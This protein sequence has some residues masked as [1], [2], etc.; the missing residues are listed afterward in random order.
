M[1][2]ILGRSWKS[3]ILVPLNSMITSPCSIPAFSAGEPSR[4]WLTMAPPFSLSPKLSASS[5]VTGWI[6]T[7]NSARV[8]LPLSLSWLT[9]SLITLTG[10]ANPMPWPR[11][12][13]AVFMPTT[14]P[15]KSNRGPPEL[16][17]LMAASV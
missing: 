13:M 10:T 16:P 1:L 11:A 5:S 14:R 3:V 4:T 7:P 9:I 12:M 17:K 6:R 2:T 8:T 15:W